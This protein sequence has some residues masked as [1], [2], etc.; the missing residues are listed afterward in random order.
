LVQGYKPVNIST[1]GLRYKPNNGQIQALDGTS[2]IPTYSFINSNTMG[3]YFENGL[4]SFTN[5]STRRMSK[6]LMV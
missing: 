3:M 2:A 4:L 5:N 6:V 1:T